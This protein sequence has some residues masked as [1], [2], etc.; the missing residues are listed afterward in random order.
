MLQLDV[1]AEAPL[2]DLPDDVREP[3]AESDVV[4]GN[5]NAL[6]GI[7]LWATGMRLNTLEIY[8]FTNDRPTELPNTAQ[9]MTSPA[10]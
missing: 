2:L 10:R 6:G 7:M 8:W 1:P 3:I 4:G 9:V 5:G